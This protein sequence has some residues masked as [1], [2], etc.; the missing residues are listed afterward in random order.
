MG[1][2]SRGQTR[3]G[4]GVGVVAM[5]VALLLAS[6]SGD[7]PEGSTVEETTPAKT[8]SPTPTPSPTPTASDEEQKAIDA[9]TSAY[10][11]WYDVIAR[12]GKSPQDYTISQM[13]TELHKV[14]GDPL[15]GDTLDQL[16]T[17]KVKGWVQS[18]DQIFDRITPDGVKLDVDK[19]KGEYPEVM[20]RVCSD[21]SKI[22]L[23]SAKTGK[24]VYPPQE[25]T[26]HVSYIT[27]WF[28]EDAWHVVKSDT[29]SLE[30]KC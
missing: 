29:R 2:V 21:T 8:S 4:A 13:K 18:G 7:A 30:E 22:D 20:L 14:G 6:C 10:R 16:N 5:A 11:R 28:Y 17:Y 27:V 1:L 15:A 26:K 24:P 19:S 23:V 12:L 9:A 25:Q 3:V